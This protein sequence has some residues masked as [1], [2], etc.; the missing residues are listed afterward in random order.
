M[1]S[2]VFAPFRYGFYLVLDLEEIAV[3]GF[4]ALMS[5]Q[6]NSTE[7]GA[8]LTGNM[9]A[10]WWGHHRASQGILAIAS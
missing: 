4:L 8:V 9:P 10:P 6:E 7:Y 1:W 5:K 3:L 2:Q